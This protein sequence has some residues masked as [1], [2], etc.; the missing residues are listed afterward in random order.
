MATDEHTPEGRPDSDDVAEAQS[1]GRFRRLGQAAQYAREHKLFASLAGAGVLAV[2]FGGILLFVFFAGDQEKPVTLEEALETLDAG[3]YDDAHGMGKRLQDAEDLPADFYGAPAFIMGTALAYEAD[4]SFMENKRPYYL[5]ASRYLSQA[6]DLGIAPE[7]EGE[8]LFLLGRAL[9]LS[10]QIPACRPVFEAA[11]EAA[12]RQRSEILWLLTEAYLTDANP[13]YEQALAWNDK[14]LSDR[15][16]RPADRR[17]GLLQRARILLGLNRRDACL[18]TLEEIPEE[19]KAQAE[20]LVI[21]AAVTMA[22]ADEMLAAEEV[23]LEQ[24]QKARAMYDEA[25]EILQAAQGRDTLSTQASRKA[26]YL[27]AVCLRRK[28]DF[29]K[30]LEQ[31][32]HTSRSN[33]E[34]AE[35]LAADFEMGELL[36]K[37][38]DHKEAVAAY[39]RSMAQVSNPNDYSNPW[40]ALDDLQRR[41]VEAFEFYL[42]EELFDLALQ[43]TESMHPLLP[44]PR[45]TELEAKC[46]SQWGRYLLATAQALEADSMVASQEEGRKQLRLAGSAYTKLAKLRIVTDFYTEDL[47]QSA[48]CHMEG[49]DYV[50]AVEV[51]QEYLNNG[52]RQRHPQAL[53]D[54][55]EAQ[56]NLGRMDGALAAFEECIEFHPRDAAAYRARL[57]ASQAH[58]EKGEMEQAEALLEANLNGHLA[59]SSIEWRD[60]LFAI[61]R[62]YHRRERYEEAAERLEEAVR[63]WP[64]SE[65][66]Q[67]LPAYYLLAECYR[68][69][70]ALLRKQV[71]NDLV[72]S[73]RQTNLRRVYDYLTKSRDYYSLV[74]QS[75]NERQERQQ[76]TEVERKTLRNCYFAIGATWFD[77]GDYENAIRA[78]TAASTRYQNSPEALEAYV[79]IARAYQRLSNPQEARATVRR[80]EEVL[81]RLESQGDFLQSTNLDAQQWQELLGWMKT[82]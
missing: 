20:A 63:R 2:L 38:G 24:Q 55:G 21:K 80:G 16:L 7:R 32:A 40:I 60:S 35:S 30:A 75:L 5:L 51:L 37:L 52:S 22:T 11:L 1:T 29:S 23:T 62:L 73:V 12:P 48:Q 79:Q 71:D 19:A 50:H 78:Y 17:R 66:D 58:A 27:T 64:P 68:A 81:K 69:H 76:L 82:L 8:G 44:T 70:A 46:R 74:Q 18:A 3:L 65:C 49:H 59:P 15:V 25:I 47:W 45:V 33:P 28:E 34:T 10:G 13:R 14:Y 9:F 41:A 39:S 56:L 53:V 77:L 43:L 54:L 4:R 61:G 57:I 42:K 6:C 36:R 67:T 72:E 26:M 31:F